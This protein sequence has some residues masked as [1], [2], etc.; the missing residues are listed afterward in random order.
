MRHPHSPV[1]EIVTFT[2]A[3]GTDDARFIAAAKATEAP[4]RAQ[5]GFVSRSLT[6]AEDGRWTDHVTWSS[7]A[8]AGAGATA[9]MAEPAFGA[10]MA[11]IHGPSVTMRHDRIHWQIG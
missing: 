1:M 6:Q 5:R 2:L 9:M 10:F 3:P 7:M 11:L 8:M 4:L